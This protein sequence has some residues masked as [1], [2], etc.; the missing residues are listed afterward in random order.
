MTPTF[1]LTA[2]ARAADASDSLVRSWF[3]RGL[4]PVRPEDRDT[5]GR[6]SPREISFNTAMQIGIAAEL[7]RL[8]IAAGR[9]CRLALSFSDIGHEGRLPGEL[10]T[11][12]ATLLVAY[13]DA[14]VA[15]I[16]RQSELAD[17]FA[18]RRA[19]SASVLVLNINSIYRNVAHRLG[20]PLTD[21]A[22]L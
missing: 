21:A 3:D 13:P 16:V 1:G 4:I 17:I 20:V 6:A 9:A 19:T 2:V 18:H 15:Q 14:P 22:M 5:D 7:A 8:G 12:S 11:D 10:F